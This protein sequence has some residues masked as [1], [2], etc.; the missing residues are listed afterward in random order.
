MKT[1]DLTQS[2]TIRYID[3]GIAHHKTDVLGQATPFEAKHYFAAGYAMEMTLVGLKSIE[4]IKADVSLFVLAAIEGKNIGQSITV[5]DVVFTASAQD[6]GTVIKSADG[7]IVAEIES[8]SLDSPM[9][10]HIADDFVVYG[11]TLLRHALVGENQE[12][13]YLIG[14][15]YPLSLIMSAIGLASM[16]DHQHAASA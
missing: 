1:T 5:N 2:E 13:T 7:R 3:A 6:L 14:V 12:Q 4:G 9:K 15:F 8:P 10:A 11:Q 16:S